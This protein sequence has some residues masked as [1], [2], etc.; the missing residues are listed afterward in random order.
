MR[1]LVKMKAGE[2]AGLRKLDV[3]N[4]FQEFDR[5]GVMRL[6]A[7]KEGGV[8]Y[9]RQVEAWGKEQVWQLQAISLPIGAYFTFFLNGNKRYI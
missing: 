4:A 8:A 5:T 3:C 2:Q 7:A 1:A 9:V 6:V